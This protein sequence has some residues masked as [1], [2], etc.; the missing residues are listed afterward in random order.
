[1]SSG[2]PELQ[3]Y[4]EWVVAANVAVGMAAVVAGSAV[5]TWM[6]QNVAVVYTVGSCNLGHLLKTSELSTG[7]EDQSFGVLGGLVADHT[8]HSHEV[9]VAAAAGQHKGFR[10]A[11][12]GRNFAAT[13]SLAMTHLRY[14][15]D[16]ECGDS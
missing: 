6:K 4:W 10:R 5:K 2:Y 3:E 16:S 14:E 13:S 15:V 11:G 12:L 7:F 8:H 1:M 9:P